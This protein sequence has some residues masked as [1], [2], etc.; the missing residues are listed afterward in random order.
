M[1]DDI[2][3]EIKDAQ[4]TLAASKAMTKDQEEKYQ[5]RRD[6][7]HEEFKVQ[8]QKGWV[9]SDDDV[10]AVQKEMAGE[11]YNPPDFKTYKDKALNVDNSGLTKE[12]P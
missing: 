10:K 3:G 4:A 12:K 11:W 2:A 1:A 7:R 8:L 6:K 5:P 9:K